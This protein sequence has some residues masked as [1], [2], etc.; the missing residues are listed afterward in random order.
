MLCNT[1]KL[2]VGSQIRLHRKVAVIFCS[3]W[4]RAPNEPW[5]IRPGIPGAAPAASVTHH[6]GEACCPA[7]KETCISKYG[8]FI[9]WKPLW[10]SA[11]RKSPGLHYTDKSSDQKDNQRSHQASWK[12]PKRS[13]QWEWMTKGI[14]KGFWRLLSVCYLS[15]SSSALQSFVV[16]RSDECALWL[17]ELVAK[18]PHHRRRDRLPASLTTSANDLRTVRAA[19]KWAAIWVMHTWVFFRSGKTQ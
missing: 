15:K 9:P 2:P 8:L 16:A 13:F 10:R 4:L 17:E 18:N 14:A 3:Q 7:D 5:C 11:S 12:L 1:G 6:A 19:E